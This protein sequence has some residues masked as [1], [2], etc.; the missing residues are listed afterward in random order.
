MI[1]REQYTLERHD[2]YWQGEP[3]L[4]K[5]VWKIVEGLL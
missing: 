4:D 2:D 3:L 5:L 1:E